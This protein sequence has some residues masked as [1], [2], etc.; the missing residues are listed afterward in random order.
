MVLKGRNDLKLVKDRDI[1][2][3]SV[4]DKGMWGEWH[5]AV[6]VLLF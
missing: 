4:T 6:V 1:K 3:W 2:L 5:G